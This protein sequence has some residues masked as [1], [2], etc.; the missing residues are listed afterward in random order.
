MNLPALAGAGVRAM[1]ARRAA[2]PRGCTPIS[3]LRP[4][5]TGRLRARSPLALDYHGTS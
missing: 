4:T 5:A 1:V 3:V 2:S